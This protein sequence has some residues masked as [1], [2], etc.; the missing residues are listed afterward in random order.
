MKWEKSDYLLL[1][2]S[3]HVSSLWCT[4][5]TMVTVGK[6]VYYGDS[7]QVSL[8]SFLPLSVKPRCFKGFS[9]VNLSGC[10]AIC[11]CFSLGLPWWLNGME[12]TCNAEATGDVGLIPG[13]GRFPGGG[14]GNPLQYSCLENPMDR[15]A[16]QVIVHGIEKSQTYW[17]ANIFTFQ[18]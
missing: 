7:S 9:S 18:T 3:H 17:V 4:N 11:Y 10:N 2:T 14:H 16:W 6:L 15:E 8:N 13:T 12:S 1:P 5:L